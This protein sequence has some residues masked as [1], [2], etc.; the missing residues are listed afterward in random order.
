MTAGPSVEQRASVICVHEEN[1]SA[2]FEEFVQRAGAGV[3]QGYG[4]AS[5]VGDRSRDGAAA[6][7]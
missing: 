5:S 3:G 2:S 4:T 1:Q 6:V 7:G